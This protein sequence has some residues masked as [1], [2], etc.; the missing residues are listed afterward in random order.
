[1]FGWFQPTCPCDVAAKHWVEDRLQW[2]T[3]QFGLHIL[4]ERSI[5]L[6]TSEFFPDAWDGTP[7]SLLQMFHRVCEYMDVDADSVQVQLY[8]DQT[9]GSLIALDPTAGFA[10]GTSRTAARRRPECHERR[11]A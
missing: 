2:L 1:M 3:R 6:P 9:P 7:R 8:S 10:A 11:S 4:L 5:V